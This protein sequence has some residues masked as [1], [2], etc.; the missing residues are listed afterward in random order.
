MQRKLPADQQSK[1]CFTSVVA[2]NNHSGVTS[3]M[4]WD[5]NGIGAKFH[6]EFSKKLIAI[7][8]NSQLSRNI[9][10]GM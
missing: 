3:F 8:T 6:G 4:K 2:S 1:E 9:N 7:F 5:K 10:F